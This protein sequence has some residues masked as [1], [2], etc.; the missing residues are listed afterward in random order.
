MKS[1]RFSNLLIV[2][3]LVL[4]TLSVPAAAVAAPA[5]L[6]TQPAA[7]TS[8]GNVSDKID[9][10]ILDELTETGEADLFVV[11]KDTADLSPAYSMSWHDCGY[12]V[13][14]MFKAVAERSQANVRGW[15]AKQNIRY[16]IFWIN[17]S[18][19]VHADRAAIEALAAFPEVAELKG[20]HVSHIFDDEPAGESRAAGEIQAPAYPWNIIFPMADQVYS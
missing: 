10:L 7:P 17:N 2:L 16:T 3:A 6:P 20:N 12:F 9:F 13:V 18:L 5:S 11:F 15:L 1:G 4:S 8:Q 19:F 14:D